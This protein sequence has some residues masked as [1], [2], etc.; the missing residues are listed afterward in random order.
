MSPASSPPRKTRVLFFGEAVTLSHVVRPH[1]LASSLDPRL[2]DVFLA[3]DPRFGRLFSSATYERRGLSSISCDEFLAKLET[4]SPVYDTKTLRRYVEEDLELIREVA[5]DVVVGDFRLSLS[6]SARLAGVPYMTISDACWSPFSPGSFPIAEHPMTRILG[7]T[8]AQMVFNVIRPAAFAYHCVPLNRVRKELGLPS[9][10]YNLKRVYTDADHVLY[11]DIPELAPLLN[12]PPTHHYLGPIRWSP[13]LPKPAW[14]DDI[15]KDKPAI[16]VTFG[17]SGKTT[18]LPLVIEALSK[19]PVSILVATAG[20]VDLDRLPPNAFVA[21]YLSGDEAAA[22]SSLMICNGGTLT[23]QQAL[24]ARIPVLGIANNMNQHLNMRTISRAGAGEMMRAGLLKPAG[25]RQTVLKILSSPAYIQA[26]GVLGQTYLKY[27]APSRFHEA[28]GAAVRGRVRAEAPEQAAV[29]VRML[30]PEVYTPAQAAAYDDMDLHFGD[31][32]FQGLAE[33]ALNMGMI[34]GR[35]L[36]VGTRNGHVSI[37]LAK[38]N[39]FLS[40]QAVDH[41]SACFDIARKN[42]RRHGVADRIRFSVAVP[43]E[44]PFP[45]RTFDLVIASNVLL[46][47]AD[48]LSFLKEIQR[49]ARPEGAILIRDIR[50][51]PE[52]LMKL[53][54]AIYT[55]RYN[56]VLKQLASNSFQ[57]ALSYS[58]LEALVKQLDLPRARVRKY[59]ISH[60]G[61]EVPAKTFQAA[62]VTPP[63]SPSLFK[64]F[65]KSLFVSHVSQGGAS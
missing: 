48:P 22:R 20:R 6:A 65:A 37:R 24:C 5:P 7:V 15:P 18:L 21:D 42:A 14:W 57:A 11:A 17:V 49:V 58:E 13:S 33:S 19:L 3:C 46:H 10:G 12:L 61:V 45:P 41:S 44:L 50:R 51:L 43:G 34:R 55:R 56:P 36:E 39:P 59:F 2:Y 53:V 9:L 62:L 8:L 4:G 23:V 64:R 25:L 47:A 63:A 38:L 29:S 52:P 28:L 40:I 30:G 32:L 1:V 35:V 26:A 16:Y 31:I 60:I 54:V 27:D